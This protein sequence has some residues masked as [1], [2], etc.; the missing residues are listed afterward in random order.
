M[1]RCQECNQISKPGQRLNKIT[2]QTRFAR[3]TDKSTGRIVGQGQEIVKEKGLCLSCYNDERIDELDKALSAN[4]FVAGPKDKIV[5]S[6]GHISK[7]NNNRL[8]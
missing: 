2:T 6:R 4:D 8:R 5:I 3:Y 1:Y 7:V